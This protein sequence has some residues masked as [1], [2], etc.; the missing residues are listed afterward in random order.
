MAYDPFF[1]EEGWVGVTRVVGGRGIQPREPTFYSRGSPERSPTARGSPPRGGIPQRPHTSH[2]GHRHHQPEEEPDPRRSLELN[3]DQNRDPDADADADPDLGHADGHGHDDKDKAIH[4]DAFSSTAFSSIAPPDLSPL[5]AGV[6]LSRSQVRTVFTLFLRR[7]C[8]RMRAE[9]AQCEYLGTLMAQRPPWMLT[10]AY[11]QYEQRVLELDKFLFRVLPVRTARQRGH[12]IA[13]PAATA[14]QVRIV[15]KLQTFIQMYV[16]ETLRAHEE[17]ALADDEDPS[18][19]GGEAPSAGAFEALVEAATETELEYLLLR[20][21][22]NSDH[23]AHFFGCRPP[24]M[25]ATALQAREDERPYDEA[26]GSPGP[27]SPPVSRHHLGAHPQQLRRAPLYPEA[28]VRFK[29]YLRP[30][31]RPWSPS[32]SYQKQ[33]R[34]LAPTWTETRSAQDH[35]GSPAEAARRRLAAAALNPGIGETSRRYPRAKTVRQRIARKEEED[36]MLTGTREEMWRAREEI[37]AEARDDNGTED[38]DINK[39]GE[40]SRRAPGGVGF[41]GLPLLSDRQQRLQQRQQRQE[42]SAVRPGGP[43][44]QSYV[45]PSKDSLLHL[46]KLDGSANPT[47]LPTKMRHP[48]HQHKPVAVPPHMASARQTLERLKHAAAGPPRKILVPEKEK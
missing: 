29:K 15:P 36:L 1:F 21:C 10:V 31:A 7:L 44:R 40:T 23:M 16:A 11:S 28:E 48:G 20:F 8:A 38:E 30:S 35:P 41:A 17:D 47:S 25:Y 33:L 39:V 37:R 12:Q 22:S 32:S 42:Q 5:A 9:A 2:E 3:F 18:A 45:P 13:T 6:H 26:A 14:P 34:A 46:F 27:G 43:V 24:P 19:E 4:I